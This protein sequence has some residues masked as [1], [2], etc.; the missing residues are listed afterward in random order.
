MQK[1]IYHGTNIHAYTPLVKE[2][3][4][5]QY[6]DVKWNAAMAENEC[7]ALIKEL[8]DEFKQHPA[9]GNIQRST[10]NGLLLDPQLG[11]TNFLRI[12][13][14]LWERVKSMDQVRHFKETLDQIGNTCIQGVSHRILIDWAAMKDD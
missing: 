3:L 6:S 5:T 9:I 4:S 12:L 14:Q 10:K 8:S 1:R 13:Q 7:N 2:L 11:N